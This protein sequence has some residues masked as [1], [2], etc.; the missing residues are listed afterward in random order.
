MSRINPDVVVVVDADGAVLFQNSASSAVVANDHLEGAQLVSV[1]HPDD[2]EAFS[3]WLSNAFI[4][5]VAPNVARWGGGNGDWR[6]LESL[7][8]DGTADPDIAGM[9][10]FARDVTWHK[11]IEDALGHHAFHDAL[12]DLANPALLREQSEQAVQRALRHGTP[13]AVLFMDLDDFKLVNDR[14][15]HAAGDVVLVVIA[16]RLRQC[17]RVS[18]TVARVGGDEFVV[19]LDDIG[20]WEAALAVANRVLKEIARPV[21]VR[22]ESVQL[23]ASIG[24][25]MLDSA[26]TTPSE[27]QHN[28]DVAMYKA[29][30][31]G[32]GRLV[33][34]NAGDGI[35]LDL[36]DG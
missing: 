11:R 18:D 20:S 19:L 30:A 1:V 12:T 5:R 4:G 27:L 6:Y 34:Y 16:Q 9:A 36:T 15:G 23:T 17:A 35:I 10:L 22:A 21:T 31:Q 33:T 26:G 2:R 14:F 3:N 32:K 8:V 24:L 28:A 29:K 7:A 25:A 13:L